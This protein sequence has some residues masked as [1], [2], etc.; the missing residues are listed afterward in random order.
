M[1]ITVKLKPRTLKHRIIFNRPLRSSLYS[2]GWF[3]YC[4]SG[5]DFV[6][7]MVN[8][9]TTHVDFRFSRRIPIKGV[10]K[11]DVVFQDA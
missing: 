4:E 3:I 1:R 2:A 11:L 10:T 6:A 5:I 7:S 8:K 9:T